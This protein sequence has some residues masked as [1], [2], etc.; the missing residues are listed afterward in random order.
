MAEVNK[1]VTQTGKKANNSDEFV[2]KKRKIWMT[3]IGERMENFLQN[4]NLWE[5]IK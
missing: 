1:Q 4:F 2:T 3:S 5:R